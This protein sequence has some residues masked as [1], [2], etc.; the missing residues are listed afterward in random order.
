MQANVIFTNTDR[1]V[2]YKRFEERANKIEHFDLSSPLNVKSHW[3]FARHISKERY[4]NFIDFRGSASGLTMLITWLYGVSNRMVFFRTAGRRYTLNIPN[5]LKEKLSLFMINYCSSK[6]YSNSN[7][8]KSIYKLTE[9]K[10]KFI[11][12]AVELK[13]L[14]AKAIRKLRLELGIKENSVVVGNVSRKHP[15]KNHSLLFVFQSLLV[16]IPCPFIM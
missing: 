14:N 10:Y 16:E 8:V 2:L 5:R 12:N 3:K 9:L 15:D 13:P 6:I 1:G 7:S 11:P 4:V